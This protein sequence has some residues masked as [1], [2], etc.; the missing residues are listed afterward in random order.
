VP[1][2]FWG[3]E[4]PDAHSI[5]QGLDT[6]SS[7]ID[8]AFYWG[9]AGVPNAGGALDQLHSIDSYASTLHNAGKL[10]MAPICLQFWGANADRYYEYSGAS[11]MRAM[12]MDAI[13]RSHPDWVEIITWNDFIEGTYV[14]PIDDPNQ[15][16][17]ANYLDASGIPLGTRSYF[18][19]HQGATA[20]LPFFIQWYKTEVEPI[21]QHDAVYFFYRS[22]PER[23]SSGKPSVSHKFG[24][25][26]DLIYITSNLT[27]PAD[28][29]ITTG[30]HVA[31][32]HLIAG[33]TD[34]QTPFYPG[35]A[36][37]FTL[38]RNGKIVVTATG[39]DPIDASPRFNNY[40][41]STGVL[42]AP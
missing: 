16:P 30:G 9:I 17:G 13:N 18:H 4:L 19:T 25:V 7:I 35:A 14:S 32:L 15:Y 10:F 31:T 21:I 36:P 20:L 40:Y 34:T 8:G 12:W 33:S 5:Q 42:T 41:D 23:T 3:G 24:P 26:A 2:F 27:A 1:A 29:T 22:Q 37:T 38:V 11:G 28:L 6:W 39:H